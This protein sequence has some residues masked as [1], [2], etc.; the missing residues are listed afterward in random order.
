MW[1]VL[2]LKGKG[3]VEERRQEG[4]DFYSFFKKKK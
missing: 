1:C 3:T 2:K 4:K